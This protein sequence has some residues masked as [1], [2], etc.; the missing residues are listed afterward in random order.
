MVFFKAMI[1][2]IGPNKKSQHN[3]TSFKKGVMDD[4]YAKKRQATKKKG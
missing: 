4:V 3:H 2:G 1:Q